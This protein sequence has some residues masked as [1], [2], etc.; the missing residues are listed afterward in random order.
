MELNELHRKFWVEQSILRDERI[1]DEVI[2]SLAVKEA[3][4]EYKR[5]PIKLSRSFE[6]ILA[7]AEE[8][9]KTVQSGLAR[10]AGRA[11]KKDALQALIGEIVLKYPNINVPQLLEMLDGEP[12]AGTVTSIDGQSEG[13]ADSLC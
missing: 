1:K 3:D 6:Q 10:H 8:T 12:G 7:E 11:P 4:S 9:K 2:L 5:I 13:L